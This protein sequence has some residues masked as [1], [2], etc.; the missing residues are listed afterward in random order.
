[1]ATVATAPTLLGSGLVKA[2]AQLAAPIATEYGA[3]KLAG[4]YTENIQVLGNDNQLYN[5]EGTLDKNG[6]YIGDYIG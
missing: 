5:I 2:A 4:N 1:M 6:N 3:D